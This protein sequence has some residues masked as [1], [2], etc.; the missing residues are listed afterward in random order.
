MKSRRWWDD[1]AGTEHITQS[2]VFR[3]LTEYHE[4]GAWRACNYERR[5][6]SYKVVK[7][8]QFVKSNFYWLV[9][10]VL[11]CISCPWMSND[12]F[13]SRGNIFK[14]YSILLKT[15]LMDKTDF[16]VKIHIDP[17]KWKLISLYCLFF[18]YA[19]ISNVF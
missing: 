5:L 7:A 9:V 8:P 3:A 12:Q 1:C 13:L 10:V 11:T 15:L 6:R 16:L 2:L 18:F 14:K 17:I 4:A 19:R